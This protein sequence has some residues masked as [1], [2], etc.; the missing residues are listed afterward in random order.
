MDKKINKVKADEKH[1]AADIKKGLKDTK[2]LL[3]ADHKQDKKLDKLEHMK[4]K[5]KREIK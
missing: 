3:K 1:A 4:K 2:S 5:K